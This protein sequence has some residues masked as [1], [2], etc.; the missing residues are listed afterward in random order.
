MRGGARSRWCYA[1]GRLAI[2]A[3]ASVMMV[4]LC[5]R[6]G[7]L[8]RVCFARASPTSLGHYVSGPIAVGRATSSFWGSCRPSEGFSA[9]RGSINRAFSLRYQLEMNEK[10]RQRP[11][12]KNGALSPRTQCAYTYIKLSLLLLPLP[13]RILLLLILLLSIWSCFRASRLP[14][15]TLT[16][17]HTARSIQTRP[18]AVL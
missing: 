10:A 15:H 11:A 13:P 5:N 8:L 18:K 6:D 9:A 7:V 17:T 14:R 2:M 16:D 12:Y 1:L 4:K 3:H